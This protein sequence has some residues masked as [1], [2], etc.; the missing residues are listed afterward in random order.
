VVLNGS[1]VGSVSSVPAGISRNAPAGSEL[2]TKEHLAVRTT[3][4]MDRRDGDDVALGARAVG[5][6]IVSTRKVR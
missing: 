1:V 6:S 2:A 4:R 5:R 3:A